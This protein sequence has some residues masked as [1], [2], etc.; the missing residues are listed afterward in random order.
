MQ[1]T[2][3]LAALAA[4][5]DAG[6]AQ[7]LASL[8]VRANG[9]PQDAQTTTTLGAYT[10]SRD[11]PVEQRFQ[12]GGG[13]SA[14]RVELSAYAPL[15]FARLFMP[16]GQ[17]R[18]VRH[19]TAA[20][21]R[22]AS[23]QIG[24]RL[25]SLQGGVANAVLGALTGSQVSLSV[26]DYNAL[27]STY[28]DLLSYIDAVHTRLNLQG[29]SFDQTLTGNVQTSDALDALADVLRPSD[30]RAAEAVGHVAASASHAAPINLHNLI[31]LA[32]Y[33]AHD[34]ATLSGQTAIQ[35]NAKDL[36]T[37]ILQIAGGD[38]QARLNLGAGVHVRGAGGERTRWRK[39]S[40]W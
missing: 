2:A 25:L 9:W 20:Q 18:I 19:A 6:D 1:G 31:D 29:E 17:M 24:S 3:D 8:T 21:T 22:M 33:G 14:V 16:E 27:L 39:I 4:I 37:A 34:H 13:S 38:R 12:S 40:D 26:M 15:Y 23:F 32:P 28:V 30:A 35:V 11:I 5:Q 10:P 7:A 36:A